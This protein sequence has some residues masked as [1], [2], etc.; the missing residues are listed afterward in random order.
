[1][2]AF[3]VDLV[4]LAARLERGRSLAVEDL[5]DACTL[6]RPAS[7]P[8]FNS[9]SGLS[10]VAAGESYYA[11]RCLVRTVQVTTSG[12]AAGERVLDDRGGAD[13]PVTVV[14]V[15]AGDVLTVTGSPDVSMVGRSF[16]VVDVGGTQRAV[17]RR[18]VLTR[19]G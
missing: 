8:V 14:D 17:V 19:N 2:R 13:V 6:A 5:V 18:L 9:V 10:T 7:V 12:D 3:V 16:R 4:S 11:G 1:M 15:A